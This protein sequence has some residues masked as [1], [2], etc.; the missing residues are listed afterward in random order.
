MAYDCNWGHD[1]I[2]PCDLFLQ[3]NPH[4]G[5]VHNLLAV[6]DDEY[7]KIGDVFVCVVA[8]DL[9]VF[10]PSAACVG[11]EEDDHLGVVDLSGDFFHDLF[12]LHPLS[13]WQMSQRFFHGVIMNGESVDVK[14]KIDDCFCVLFC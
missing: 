2:D 11:A 6:Y 1:A 5:H 9:Y 14:S 3:A 12:Q 13:Q 7:V 8:D 4:F 10:Y